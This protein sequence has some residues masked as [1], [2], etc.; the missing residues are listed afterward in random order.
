MSKRKWSFLFA[1]LLAQSEAQADLIITGVIDGPLTGGIPK[2]IEVYATDDID[3]LSI[4]ALGSP[5]NGA[6]GGT[7]EFEFPSGTAEAGDF[8]YV[9]S[10]TA[11]FNN[12]FGFE[13]DFTNGVAS[14]NGDDAIELFRNGSVVDTF[15]EV[16][17]DGTEPV[18]YTH[19][20]LPTS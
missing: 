19:L 12:F 11:E 15:G 2:A 13:P 7:I 9:A 4:Y 10:E 20:T 18:S 6:A 1:C 14:I 3:D 16:G 5:N 8:F 17:V